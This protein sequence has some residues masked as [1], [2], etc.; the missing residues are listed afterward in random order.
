VPAPVAFLIALL[1]I[2]HVLRSLLGRD[3]MFDVLYRFAFIPARYSNSDFYP[4]GTGAEIW[5]VLSYAFLHADLVHLTINVLW[6]ASFGSAL[7]QRIG[8]A[9]FFILFMLGSIAG[10]ALHY[11]ALPDDAAPLVGASAGVSALMAATLRFAFA[12]G[13]PLAGGR[14][15]RDSYYVPAPALLESLANQRVLAFILLWF[16]VNLMFGAGSFGLVGEDNSI[17]WQ[18]HIGGF[19]AGLFLFPLFDPVRVYHDDYPG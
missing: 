11:L 8:A 3:A 10:A 1:A 14:G 16:A 13:G 19:L 15:R 17:A 12:S 4:G 2:V 6:M 7:A 5:S 18:A 9:R